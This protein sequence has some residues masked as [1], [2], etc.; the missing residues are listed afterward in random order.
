MGSELKT[1]IQIGV[2]AYYPPKKQLLICGSYRE[3][4]GHKNNGTCIY[5]YNDTHELVKVLD[6]PY[7]WENNQYKISGV[8]CDEDNRVELLMREI[9]GEYLTW[10]MALDMDTYKLTKISYDPR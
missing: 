1:D 9:G 4:N 5:I 3:G 7:V 8:G 10:H 6:E 2:V